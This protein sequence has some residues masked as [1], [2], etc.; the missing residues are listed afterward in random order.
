M[1]MSETIGQLVASFL[2]PPDNSWTERGS[3][4]VKDFAN[5]D[6]DKDKNGE[7]IK[8]INVIII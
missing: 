4:L 8:A 5:I 1:S 3:F 2:S 6:I 7:A